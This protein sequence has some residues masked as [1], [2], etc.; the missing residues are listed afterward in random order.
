MRL[1][2]GWVALLASTHTVAVSMEG[3]QWVASPP[4]L[5]IEEGDQ[6]LFLPFSPDPAL[7]AQGADLRLSATPIAC[8]ACHSVDGSAIV[9]PSWKGLWGRYETLDDGSKVLV[10]DHYIF[11]SI[12]H[13]AEA[14]ACKVVSEE[15]C[16]EPWPP[17][18]PPIYSPA[19]FPMENMRAVLAYIQSLSPMSQPFTIQVEGGKKLQTPF[20]DFVMGEGSTELMGGVFDEAWTRLAAF[21]TAKRGHLDN[22]A[23]FVAIMEEM[24]SETPDS[25]L[26]D[27]FKRAAQHQ[28]GVD[29]SAVDDLERLLIEATQLSLSTATA[30]ELDWLPGIG[31]SKAAKIIAAREEG[32]LSVDTLTSVKGIGVATRAKLIPFLRD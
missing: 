6:V 3:G 18:M 27:A 12:H 8:Q 31:P 17:T 32:N 28:H 19:T 25:L 21:R 16:I 5:V 24:A 23:A 7:V 10:D 1:Y 14:I 29:H 26:K 11:H 15:T 4:A 2:L 22:H 9:G 30:E 20:G 13:P